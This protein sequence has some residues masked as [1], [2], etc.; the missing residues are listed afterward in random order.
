MA[1]L[2]SWIVWLNTYSGALLFIVAAVTGVLIYLQVREASRLRRE[3][4]QPYVAVDMRQVGSGSTNARAVELVVKNF[5]ATAAHNIRLESEP[6]LVS[7]DQLPGDW[8]AWGIFDVLPTLVPGQE[9]STLWEDDAADRTQSDL[10]KAHNVTVRCQDSRG[11]K[12][13]PVVFCLDWTA[14]Q[15]KIFRIVNGPHEIHAELEKIRKELATV[16]SGRARVKVVTQTEAE[17]R[18]QR[19]AER[20]E[21]QKMAKRAEAGESPSSRPS[22]RPG[23]HPWQEWIG[24]V[25]AVLRTRGA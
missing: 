5:G 19:A 6:P 4:T 15:Y 21:L 13:E 18:A 20:D 2:V 25:Q 1:P 11:R 16:V 10:P 9:W 3:Q 14:H 12:L 17:H 7:S 24:R 22:D 23:Q 8:G